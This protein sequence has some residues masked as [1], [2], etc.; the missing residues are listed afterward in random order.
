MANTPSP[1][2]GSDGQEQTD[3]TEQKKAEQEKPTDPK[4]RFSH[5]LTLA[6]GSNVRFNIGDDPNGPFPSEINGVPVIGARNA[7]VGGP[8]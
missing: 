1:V 5:Y 2:Y 8:A 7:T 6:D 4:D 3:E